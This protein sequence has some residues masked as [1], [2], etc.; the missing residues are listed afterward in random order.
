MTVV[1][2]ASDSVI[3]GYDQFLPE[4]LPFVP[5]CP[6]VVALNAIRNACIEFCDKS[7]YWLY[8]HIPF[9]PVEDT[10]TYTLSIPP[11]TT[12]VDILSAW[13]DNLPL[14]PRGEDE[15][16]KI[17]PLNYP[18]VGGS[19]RYITQRTQSSVT[20]VPYPTTVIENA[21]TLTVAL[22]PTRA[23]SG[24]GGAIYEN[25]AEGISY[26]ARARIHALPNQSFSDPMAAMKYAM[27]FNTVI[28]K[29]TIARNRGLTRA[30]Q[31]VRPPRFF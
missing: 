24:V 4:V 7:L 2:D 10:A 16:T 5:E 23:S 19:P 30:T 11:G 26:G 14:S 8:T 25:W 28:G 13:Y 6:E 18:A 1:I 3:I 29:A 15:L 20:L 9:S 21:V 27:M 12:A 31:R 22:K 17:Y